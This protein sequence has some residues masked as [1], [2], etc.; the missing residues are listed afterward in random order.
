MNKD[1]NYLLFVPSLLTRTKSITYQVGEEVYIGMQTNEAV[2]KYL[3]DYLQK[4]G[5]KLD[6][7]I[8]LC[9]REVEHDRIEWIG[10]QTT[11]EYYQDEIRAFL[12]DKLPQEGAENLFEIVPYTS[13]NDGES[14]EITEPLKQVLRIAG[15]EKL[16]NKKHLFVDFTG[17][18][19]S[20]ALLLLF[21]CRILQKSGVE[22][23]KILYSNISSQGDEGRVEECTRTYQ[24]FGY[25]EA[26]V[27]EK[28]GGVK[29]IREYAKTLDVKEK[30]QIEKLVNLKVKMEES[31]KKNQLGEVAQ[32]AKQYQEELKKADKLDGSSGLK[33]AVSILSEN[34]GKEAENIVS[35]GR[36]PELGVIEE[37][38]K[39]GDYDKALNLFRQK[40]LHTLYGGKLLKV[41]GRFLKKN[42][43]ENVLQEDMLA[44][45]IMGVYCY[46][47]EPEPN[48]FSGKHVFM[49]TV[50]D[51]INLLWQ[52]PRE[53]PKKVLERYMGRDFYNLNNYLDEVPRWGFP[54]NDYSLRVA[55]R[56]VLPYLEEYS[57]SGVELEGIIDRY[58][59]LDRLYMS[60]GFPFACTYDKS[61]MD[62]YDEL[63][64]KILE[65]G[66]ESLQRLYQGKE[67]TV[68]QRLKKAFPEEDVKYEALVMKLKEKDQ[69]ELLHIL[70]PF[71]LIEKNISSGVIKGEEWEEFIYNFAKSFYIIKSVRN[72][73]IHNGQ[74]GKKETKRAIE[75][76]KRFMEFLKKYIK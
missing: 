19:R 72:K 52:N 48:R 61:I 6:K 7:I 35:K 3:I 44:K 2:S 25:L 57:R 14:E 32:V 40:I 56:K 41:N 33:R 62:K 15:E 9:S 10:G 67:D 12:K 43:K 31:K 47:E 74:L 36:L 37:S 17:G 45:E 63:Y 64:K 53:E 8:M 26:E 70:F 75:E 58:I 4:K 60:Y 66:A 55:K 30:K 1:E 39:R 38:I 24:L 20:A 27:E 68:I 13:G 50:C 22:V 46:Y 59:Q 11:L 42:G 65:N 54:H 16:E 76:L 49:D 71:R 28:N 51:Y 23:E 29:K 18:T 69:E 21:A 5:E 34:S 73:I